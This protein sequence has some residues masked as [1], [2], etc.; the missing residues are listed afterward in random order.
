MEERYFYQIQSQQE[1]IIY[2]V[3]L[4]VT[5]KNACALKKHRPA[6]CVV[7]VVECDTQGAPTK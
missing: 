7:A 5:E 3:F 1:H 6:Q 4:F 2:F